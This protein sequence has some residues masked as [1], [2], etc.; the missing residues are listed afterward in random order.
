[1]AF[2]KFVVK[3]NG[4]LAV[5]FVIR[6]IVSFPIPVL[7]GLDLA[8]VLFDDRHVIRL[9]ATEQLWNAFYNISIFFSL[10]ALQYLSNLIHRLRCDRTRCLA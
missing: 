10:N 6:A 2:H 7:R 1:M 4:I 5:D 8:I 3:L 9:R